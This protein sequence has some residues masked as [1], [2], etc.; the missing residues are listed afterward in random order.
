MPESFRDNPKFMSLPRLIDVRNNPDRFIKVI[1]DRRALAAVM[2]VNTTWLEIEGRVTQTGGLVFVTPDDN[3]KYIVDA[4]R[5]RGHVLT[6]AGV[7]RVTVDIERDGVIDH[8]IAATNAPVELDSD[9]DGPMSFTIT[10][11][12]CDVLDPDTGD[13]LYEQGSFVI[14][15]ATVAEWTTDDLVGSFIA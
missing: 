8:R 6:G 13:K 2:R 3:T 9:T 7:Q 10:L 11:R 4:E 14:L 15:G 12:D 5:F 1:E